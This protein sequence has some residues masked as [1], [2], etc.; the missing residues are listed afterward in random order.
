LL[1]LSLAFATLGDL[2]VDVDSHKR[3]QSGEEHAEPLDALAFINKEKTA[4]DSD[5]AEDEGADRSEYLDESVRPNH[6]VFDLL[7]MQGLGLELREYSFRSPG[8]DSIVVFQ[9]LWMRERPRVLLG[10]HD[11]LA[12]FLLHLGLAQPAACQG[13][14]SLFCHCVDSHLHICSN[15]QPVAL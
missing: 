15:G 10:S 9:Y 12:G 3:G 14:A 7:T 11:G 13:R 5:K 6:Q 8:N 2:T 4:A 1:G